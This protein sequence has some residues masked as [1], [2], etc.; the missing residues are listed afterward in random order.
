MSKKL[1]ISVFA[2][3]LTLLILFQE[4]DNIR[5]PERLQKSEDSIQF[6]KLNRRS[7]GNAVGRGK[8]S[9][10]SILGGDLSGWPLDEPD[11]IK[12]LELDRQ[13]QAN[14]SERIIEQ[15]SS[16]SEIELDD[17]LRISFGISED[18]SAIS[19][20]KT[21]TVV[22]PLDDYESQIL[23]HQIKDSFDLTST[24]SKMKDLMIDFFIRKYGIKDK[25]YIILTTDTYK[26]G[27]DAVPQRATSVMRGKSLQATADQGNRTFYFDDDFEVDGESTDFYSNL[28]VRYGHLID[29]EAGN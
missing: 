17:S 10:R 23:I 15:G 8:V 22:R 28:Q 4:N 9:D 20:L 3:I 5:T 21:Q 13:L 12:I 11:L 1:G 6:T 16:T 18:Y 29:F 19:F 7:S 14:E 25:K 27:V 26:K 24:D 2:V